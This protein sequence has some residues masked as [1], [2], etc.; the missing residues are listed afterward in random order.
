MGRIASMN[1]TN[2]TFVVRALRS[3]N[4]RLFFGGQSISLIGTW[5]TRVATGWLVYR[6]TGSSVL[7]GVVSFAGQA[8]AFFLAPLAGVLVDRWDRHRTLVITQILSMLQSFA[9]AGLALTGLITVWNIVLL[10]I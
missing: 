10:A 1:V 7:L 9:I 8:P 4:Y 3:P 6:L 2:W 5:M